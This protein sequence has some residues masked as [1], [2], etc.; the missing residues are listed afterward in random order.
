MNPRHPHDAD[1]QMSDAEIERVAD[2]VFEKFRAQIGDSAVKVVI[3]SITI[4]A[5]A[6]LVWLGVIKNAH[7]AQ[8][9][10]HLQSSSVAHK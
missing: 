5:L 7:A 4:G 9:V 6:L 10:F 2:R 3:W 1:P 8:W